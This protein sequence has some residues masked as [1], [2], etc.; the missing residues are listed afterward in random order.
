[1]RQSW[2][3]WLSDTA[4]YICASFWAG[5][6]SGTSVTARRPKWGGGEFLLVGE[7]RTLIAKKAGR[8][9][10]RLN[11]PASGAK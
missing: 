4:A 6:E 11:F 8:D 10:V 5:L 7:K 1:M 9:L 2:P 3:D